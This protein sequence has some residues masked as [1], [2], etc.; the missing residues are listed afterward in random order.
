M[1]FLAPL[2]LMLAAAAAVPL[3]IHL[4]RR[5]TGARVDFPA[6]RYLA[7][8]EQE[9]SRR[10]KLRNLLLMM[11]RVAAVLLLAA[12]AAYPVGRVGGTGHAPTAMA[13][14]LDNSLSTSAIAAGRPVLA[15]LR[16][17]ARAV[18]EQASEV[19][20]L[21]LVTADG[22]VQ[23]GGARAITAAIDAVEPLA[24]A[25]DLGAAAARAA[26]LVR[27]AGLAERRVA[28]V[29]D[30]QAT[31]WKEP[32]EFGD[33]D[34][35]AFQ[36]AEPPP[37]NRAVIAAGAQPARWTPRGAAVATIATH[38]SVTYRMTLGP[39]T[40][41]RGTAVPSGAARAVTEQVRVRAAPAE[42][43]WLAG[44]VEI[45][46]D[47]LRAD[48][49]RHFA[50]WVGAPPGVALDPATGAFVRSAVEAIEA[51]GL[52]RAG[53]DVAIVPAD[54]V[55]Q[56]PAL[57]VAPSD[58]VRAGA[59]NRALARAGIP[60][61]LGPL[62]RGQGL[63]RGGRLEGIEVA[64]RMRLVAE[65]PASTD[66]LARVGSDPWV[67]AGP[68]YVLVASPLDPRATA[69]PARAAFIPWMTDMLTQRLAGDAGVVVAAAP[70]DT[71]PR[72]SW[73]EEME[74]PDAIRRP[75]AGPSFAA[76]EAPGVYFLVRGG[77]RAGAL[78]VN[79]EGE[80]SALAR[81]D[82]AL[83]RERL[84]GR[85][86]HVFG[87]TSGWRAGVFAGATRRPLLAPA[88]AAVA[89]LLIAES[90]VASYGMRRAA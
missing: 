74:M 63:V 90:V 70:G 53:D 8:A 18:A 76:P 26:A 79:A 82:P 80:E 57:I 77:R 86:S 27:G 89:L 20:R 34:V 17:A 83:L 43:G 36:P 19:D 39:R 15:E 81:H 12:A 59:A 28:I 55:R 66:T 49:I 87:E 64:E 4:L 33:A 40:L 22:R 9:H 73:A 31:A 56:L 78:V 52:I 68:G 44:A 60:W 88:L 30:G 6:V 69:L 58:P 35:V 41:A 11:L 37:L 14:L 21:W 71:I 85:Q 25:G 38:D 10:L 2:W 32:V 13:I 65:G 45:A 24:G 72:P 42:Q 23:G 46:P 67:V 7:R 47:E 16:E 29:T 50:A 75:L 84:R 51:S 61:R 3:L 62:V 5:R 54:A 48:N 1:S